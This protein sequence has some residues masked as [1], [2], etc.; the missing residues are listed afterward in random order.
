MS[1]EENKALV[2]RALDAI[3]N[4]KRVERVEDFF[5]IGAS[6]HAKTPGEGKEGINRHKQ[7]SSATHTGEAVEAA[8]AAS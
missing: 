6:T 7:I 2:H 3:W 5:D 1:V 8:H 4:E